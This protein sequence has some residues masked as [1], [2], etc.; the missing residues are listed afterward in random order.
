MYFSSGSSAD[1]SR[2]V[3][4]Q[5]KRLPR[6]ERRQP[7]PQSDQTYRIETCLVKR[8]LCA[9]A[10]FCPLGIVFWFRYYYGYSAWLFVRLSG[11]R[12][13]Y[14]WLHGA[15]RCHVTRHDYPYRFPRSGCTSTLE[16]CEELYLA[17]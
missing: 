4:W 5:R 17:F 6:N 9:T 12:R 8:Y 13:G 2:I 7:S 15:I 10:G 3:L 1:E 16:D 11:E 14:V